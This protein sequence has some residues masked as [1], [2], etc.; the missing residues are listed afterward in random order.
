MAQDPWKRA[1]D[2]KRLGSAPPA[3]ARGATPTDKWLGPA[4]IALGLALLALIVTGVTAA[5]I[6]RASWLPQVREELP[7][8]VAQHVPVPRVVVDYS[9]LEQGVGHGLVL[10][11]SYLD[12]IDQTREMEP[13]WQVTQ[14]GANTLR[15]ESDGI[16]VYVQDGL[17]RTYNLDV[18]RFFI[19]G[20]WKDW[21]AEWQQAGI[22]PE[23]SWLEFTGEEP[24][25]GEKTEHLYISA[26]SVK[27]KEGWMHRA[28]NL[29]FRGGKLAQLE[30]RLNFGPSDIAGGG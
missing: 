28:F 27:L 8:A 19:S 10:M 20:K 17:I 11:G 9:A 18:A 5:W 16:K 26:E 12:L 6:Y 13:D 7:P 2:R 22:F 4:P 15:L 30:G 3:E 23:L 14:T 24:R 1:Y 25:P 29:V 21:R